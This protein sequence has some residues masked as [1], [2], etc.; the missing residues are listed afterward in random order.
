[1]TYHRLQFLL[2]TLFVLTPWTPPAFGGGNWG[3]G[4]RQMVGP[5]GRGK[6]TPRAQKPRYVPKVRAVPRPSANYRVVSPGQIKAPFK[7]NY[8]AAAKKSMQQMM[9]DP[10]AYSKKLA[11]AASLRRGA[12]STSKVA[13][14]L[15]RSYR[16]IKNTSAFKAATQAAKTGNWKKYQSMMGKVKSQGL[17]TTTPNRRAQSSKPNVVVPWSPFQP[18]GVPTIPGLSRS[19]QAGTPASGSVPTAKPT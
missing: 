17:V 7:P 2:A 11:M 19:G 16:T 8:S 4:P 18:G 6:Y 15:S 1:M 3:A 13:P 5:S 12:A 10:K 14:N 9:K